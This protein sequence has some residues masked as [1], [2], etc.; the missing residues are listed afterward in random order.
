[1]Q[2]LVG[3]NWRHTLYPSTPL[4][5]IVV[6]G[7]V[8]YL[9]LFLFLRVVLKREG[10][11]MSITDILVVVLIADAAQNGMADNYHSVS[12]GLLLVLVIVGWAYGLDRLSYRFPAVRRLL[13]SG[14]VPLVKDGRMLR[15][16]LRRELV[17]EDELWAHLRRQGVDRIEDVKLAMVESDGT[18]S[19]VRRSDEPDAPPPEADSSD[20]RR[21][22]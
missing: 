16:N 19:V 5:E 10:A 14:P 9:G 2:W 4:L 13:K 22:V 6:R 8:M 1:M 7:T 12:D 11:A 17:T 20:R 21:L 18:I 15:Q 3:V